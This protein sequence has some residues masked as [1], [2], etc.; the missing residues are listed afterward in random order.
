MQKTFIIMGVSG[1]G[2]TTI[3]QKLSDELSIPFV[4][5]DDFHPKENVQKMSEGIPLN[6]ED[7]LPWLQNLN[8][9]LKENQHHKGSILACS[10]LKES[11]REI[12][13]ENIQVNWIYLKGNFDI[14]QTR[15]Q[16]REDHFMNA[17]LLQSQFDTLEEPSYGIHVSIDQSTENILREI[18]NTLPDMSSQLGIIG[19]GVMGKSLA[20]NAAEKGISVSVYNRA[21]E[22][23]EH[24][25]P[26]FLKEHQDF[27]FQGFTDLEAF[28]NS[29]ERPRKILLMIKAGTA[30]DYVTNDILSYLSEGD[31]LIDG[32]NSYF[33]DTK[34]RFQKSKEVGIHFIGMG[35]SGGES[36]AR[37]GPSMMPGGS[38]ESYS[39]VANILERLAAKDKHGNSCCAYVGK[40]GA[41]HFVKMIHNG[42]EYGEMQ[43][44]AEVYQLLSKT[45]SYP[46][47]SEILSE[48]NEG[49][50]HSFLLETTIKILNEQDENGYVLDQILDKSGSKGTGS[51]SARTALELGKSPNVMTAAVFERYLSSL[52]SDRERHSKKLPLQ[53]E[54][55]E[56]LDLDALKDAFMFA[57]TINLQQGFE[58]IRA[59]SEEYD[60]DI[61]LSEV[62]RIWTNGCIIKSTQMENISETFKSVSSLLD[63]SSIFEQ[64]TNYEKAII[65]T[66]NYSMDQRVSAPCFSNA[67]NYWISITTE[68]LP[69]NLI[70]AQRDFFGA[71]TFQK[72]GDSTETFYHHQW[73]PS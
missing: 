26:Y 33:P 67:Y 64:L 51:W 16:Q 41:G 15:L 25:V 65:E 2:K 28:V 19:L 58:V 61:N 34:R 47:I 21:S 22:G 44:L 7:R 38:E 27:S 55:S 54:S 39:Q 13:S 36:G 57:K 32:G 73:N 1:C 18:L 52:K 3:A 43:L 45:K 9:F 49:A 56:T 31:I 72:V 71:H 42:I 11:Y 6:D 8:T 59:A 68:K 14:I 50:H 48:W 46:E 60:W 20:L 23:E 4:D 40:Q 63:D 24:I 37:T 10:S 35:V 70:Q 12:L 66:L 29:L 62:S 5:A 30:V 17:S 53:E 69:A